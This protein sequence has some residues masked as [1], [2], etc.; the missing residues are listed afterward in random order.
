MQFALYDFNYKHVNMT[1]NSQ[2]ND[3]P[4]LITDQASLA[5]SKIML[6]LTG[7]ACQNKR[8]R[9]DMDMY[10]DNKQKVICCVCENTYKR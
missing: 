5:S 10:K 3:W 6:R 2:R 4:W 9:N 1:C 7:T 8:K